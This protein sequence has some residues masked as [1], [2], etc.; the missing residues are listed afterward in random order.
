MTRSKLRKI[1]RTK[2]KQTHAFLTGVPLAGAMLVGSTV[3]HAQQV[4]EPTGGL[5]EVGHSAQD[6]AEPAGRAGQHPGHRH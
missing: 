4:E 2:S 3:V 1:R 5:A 6:P